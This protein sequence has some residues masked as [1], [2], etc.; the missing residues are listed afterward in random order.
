MSPIFLE[1]LSLPV[2]E[3]RVVQRE[4]S[5]EFLEMLPINV[6]VVLKRPQYSIKELDFRCDLFC[7]VVSSFKWYVDVE[8]ITVPHMSEEVNDKVLHVSVWVWLWVCVCVEQAGGVGGFPLLPNLSTPSLCHLANSLSSQL[9]NHIRPTCHM[10][11]KSPETSLFT[12]V[13]VKQKQILQKVFGTVSK[14]TT[15]PSAAVLNQR[16]QA[17]EMSPPTP[18]PNE[19][20]LSLLPFWYRR[21]AVFLYS[22]LLCTHDSM[23]YSCTCGDAWT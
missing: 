19:N 4:R 23:W 1:H 21:R 13:N 18:P 12:T 17:E 14:E 9:W 8:Q 15:V 2:C 6:A 3:H 16:W 7:C 20:L 10:V 11:F 22:K 5:S